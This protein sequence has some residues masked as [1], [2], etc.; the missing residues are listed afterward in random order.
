MWKTNEWLPTSCRPCVDRQTRLIQCLETAEDLA[1]GNK[2]TSIVKDVACAGLS[3]PLKKRVCS[4]TLCPV[5]PRFRIPPE[6]A[7]PFDM[8]PIYN[9]YDLGQSVISVEGRSLYVDAVLAEGYPKPTV[10]WLFDFDNGTELGVGESLDRYHVFENGTLRIDDVRYEDQGLVETTAINSEGEDRV[11]F[12]I[13]IYVPPKIVSLK[14]Y[15]NFKP[16]NVLLDPYVMVRPGDTVAMQCRISGSPTPTYRWF[17][18]GAPVIYEGRFKTDSAGCLI[19]MNVAKADS[20]VYECVAE[21]MVGVDRRSVSLDVKSLERVWARKYFPCSHECGGG[22]QFIT[23]ECRNSVTKAK[24]NDSECSELPR[25]MSKRVKCNPRACL[26]AESIKNRLCTGNEKTV[27][28]AWI[29]FEWSKCT[30]LCGRGK[31][32]RLAKCVNPCTLRKTKG[33]APSEKPLRHRRCNVF[34]C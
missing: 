31:Q 34:R 2:S 32:K 24:V 13:T 22:T 1:L 16:V 3:I 5:A 33:C 8:S 23:S 26:D 6:P 9:R 28:P 18:N 7:M 25:P 29:A 17:R 11:V 19:I 27:K 20:D 30:K 14:A 12:S 21:N 15:R 4:E 10:T